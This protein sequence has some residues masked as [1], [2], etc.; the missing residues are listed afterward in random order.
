MD[1]RC[2]CNSL[3]PC[4]WTNW[5]PPIYNRGLNSDS[6]T[7]AIIPPP[8][9]NTTGYSTA[10]VLTLYFASDEDG[11]TGHTHPTRKPLC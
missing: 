2:V 8:G 6:A 1:M 4:K 7:H 3:V 5:E 11:I 9:Q 10:P